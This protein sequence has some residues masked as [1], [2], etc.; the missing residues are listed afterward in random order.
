M[1]KQRTLKKTA[2]LSGIALHTGARATLRI[3]PADADSGIRF[4][5]I[6]LP[7]QPE[8]TALASNV[9]DVRRGTTI[10]SGNAVVYTVEHIMAAL[11]ACQI[12]NAVVEMDGQE[13]P[14]VDGSALP[15]LEMII[16]AG[17]IEQDA[18]AKYWTAKAPIVVDEGDTKM[19]IY[20]SDKLEVSCLTSFSGV[21]YDPQYFS[22]TVT[23]ESFREQI[24]SARTFVAYRD[25]EQLLAMGLVKGGSLD[26]AAII[27]DGA[28]ICKD[29]LRF[30]NEI[31]RHKMLDII[32]DIFLVGCRVKASIIAIK[33]GHPVNVKLAGAMLEARS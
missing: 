14:I 29:G 11:H 20:P 18:E 10:A 16:E 26:S 3:Q 8:V 21:P 23:Q 31:V 17:I 24:A 6:D 5:R 15:Y 25:L 28:I 9:V 30:K 13:A 7:G 27:H 4:R 2:V 33:P 1:E 12:D 22:L 32:G 19:V